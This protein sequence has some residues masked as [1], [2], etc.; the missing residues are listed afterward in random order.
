MV[1][2][3]EENIKY[4]KTSNILKYSWSLKTSKEKKNRGSIYIVDLLLNLS[5]F[6]NMLQKLAIWITS[7]L[8]FLISKYGYNIFLMQSTL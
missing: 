3:W 4:T 8:N 7:G 6:A 1:Q 5:W 2:T